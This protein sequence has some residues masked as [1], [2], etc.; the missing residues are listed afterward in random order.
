[1]SVPILLRTLVIVAILAFFIG[2]RWYVSRR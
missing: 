1:M 2:V